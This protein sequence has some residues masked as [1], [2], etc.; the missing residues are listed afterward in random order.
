MTR[1]ARLSQKVDHTE[2]TTLTSKSSTYR[3]TSP[4]RKRP[5]PWDPPK[6]LNVGLRQ[7]LRGVRLI[8]KVS[9]YRCV[10]HGHPPFYSSLPRWAY[11]RGTSLIKNCLPPG[12]YSRPMPRALRWSEGEG[13]F[14]VS[15]VLLYSQHQGYLSTRKDL[16]RGRPHTGV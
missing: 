12:P 2:W 5:R 14:L 6:T 7:G 11:H 1:V 3:C 9:L 8:I 15:E 13:Q 16:S 10:Q 4:M